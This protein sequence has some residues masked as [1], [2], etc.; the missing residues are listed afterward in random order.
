VRPIERVRVFSPTEGEAAK[1]AETMSDEL[2]LDIETVGS[3][4]AAVNGADVAVTAT[5]SRVPFFPASLLH[6]GLHL[7]CMQRDEPTDECIAAAD[8]AVFHTKMKELEYVSSD[9]APIESRY[10][11]K[12]RDHPHREL[13]W[14]DFPDLGELVTGKTRTRERDDQVTLFLN[15]TG[16]GAQF[17]AL[18]HVIYAGAKEL[19]LGTTVPSEL[20]VESIQP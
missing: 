2:E 4:E 9:F 12:M 11:F 14:N 16:V 15:S 18:A 5:N 19:G 17:T 3:M 7:S 8:I 10:D 6:P 1:F 20:F 13:N